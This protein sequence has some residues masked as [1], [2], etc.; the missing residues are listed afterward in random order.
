M[1][2]TQNGPVESFGFGGGGRGIYEPLSR[3]ELKRK[4]D[5]IYEG[6][7]GDLDGGTL[8]RDIFGWRSPNSKPVD[9]QRH[10]WKHYSEDAVFANGNSIIEEWNRLQ[11]SGF[12]VEQ[13]VDIMQRSLDTGDWTLPL[14]IIP[15]V[16][17]VNPEL[18]PAANFI[19]RE[20]TND[21]EVVATPVTA[22]PDFEWGLEDGSGDREY[23][24][25]QP[26][27][28][29]DTY[30]VVGMGAATRVSD[31]MILA[32]NNL[33][34]AEGTQE[35]IFMR[36]ATVELENQIVTGSDASG[37]DGW[38]DLG[39]AADTAIDETDVDDSNEVK[40]YTEDLVDQCEENGAPLSNIAVFTDFEWHRTLRR[41]YDDIQRVTPEPEVDV[42][43]ATFAM[44][45]GEVPVFKTHALPR[46]S[47]LESDGSTHDH[48]VAVNMGATYLGVLQET[49]VKG[50]GKLGPQERF[51]VDH[52]STLVDE[53][54]GDHIVIGQVE[55]TA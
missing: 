21:D 20:S 19:A 5:D 41:A 27:Y 47:D 22:L 38:H 49:S 30:P 17:V 18:T 15:D 25:E 7:F 14:D 3:S 26:T 40:E 6:C 34:S 23:D 24:Y 16:F 8:Y 44:E 1:S 10:R 42:G 32:A 55:T 39:T 33:R 29:D 4:A 11:S 9:L 48:A 54:D 12:S 13:T 52:Y 37:F 28:G 46:V 45:G 50:L 51:A 2:Q 35:E 31:K 53:S 43:F 36:G